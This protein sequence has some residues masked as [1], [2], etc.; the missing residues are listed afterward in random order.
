ML[1]AGD[2]WLILLITRVAAAEVGLDWAAQA[3]PGQSRVAC[4][5]RYRPCTDLD[6]LRR[7]HPACAA[8]NSR[9]LTTIWPKQT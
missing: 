1:L 6:A 4:R 9:S 5:S 8:I 7:E 3:W 2:E